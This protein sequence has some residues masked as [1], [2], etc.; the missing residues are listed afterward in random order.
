M[1]VKMEIQRLVTRSLAR[2]GVEKVGLATA[3]QLIISAAKTIMG[4]ENTKRKPFLCVR[5]P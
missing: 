3:Y 4:R 2:R 1:K 5:F